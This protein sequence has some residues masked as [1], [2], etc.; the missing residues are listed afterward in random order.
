M[1]RN[2]AYVCD[3]CQ[4]GKQF[5]HNVSFSQRKTKR[6]WKPNLQVK[7]L[8]FDGRKRKVKI[9][10]QCLRTYRK[11]QESANKDTKPADQKPES[12]ARS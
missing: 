9:C 2:M 4:K 8:E 10:A 1:W 11:Q 6:V 7:H 12:A 5:G 3:I